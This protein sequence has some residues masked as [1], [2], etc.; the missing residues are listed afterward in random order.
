M[1]EKTLIKITTIEEARKWVGRR[2]SRSGYSGVDQ[3]LP[4][5]LNDYLLTLA[6]PE[7]SPGGVFQFAGWCGHPHGPAVW[8]ELADGPAHPRPEGDGWVWC[9]TAR[10]AGD[11]FTG[12][13]CEVDAAPW[14]GEAYGAR[15]SGTLH[16]A[17]HIGSVHV[18]D[19]FSLLVRGGAWIRETSCEEPAE[20]AKETAAE[21]IARVKSYEGKRV[22]LISCDGS[23]PR[24]SVGTLCVEVYGDRLY[25]ALGERT[26]WAVGDGFW[27]DFELVDPVDPVAEA[28]QALADARESEG[29]AWL[30]KAD[31]ERAHESAVT[32]RERAEESLAKARAEQA[33]KESAEAERKAREEED[34]RFPLPEGWEWRRTCKDKPKAVHTDGRSMGVGSKDGQLWQTK[35]KRFPLDVVRAVLARHDAETAP[36]SWVLS[37]AG[38][39]MRS[40]R[41]TI[42]KGD[43]VSVDIKGAVTTHTVYRKDSDGDVYLLPPLPGCEGGKGLLASWDPNPVKVTKLT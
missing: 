27:S 19:G 17:P 30:R 41:H 37:G 28:E 32:V 15:S 33:E 1:T 39:A 36:E 18:D 10:K 31:T 2:A 24:K 14:P 25:A 22:R 6:P 38:S 20:P 26:T 43:K 16:A 21:R 40:R 7:A 9:Q 5:H 29:R 13:V 8:V 34:A 35:N 12:K 3:S 11:L 42:A 23:T 4:A